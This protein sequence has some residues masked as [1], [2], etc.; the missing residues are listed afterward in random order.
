MRLVGPPCD[1]DFVV[2]CLIVDDSV[3]FLSS[4]RRLLERQGMAVAGVASSGAEALLRV[5]E[6]QPD[7]V[8]LDI[9]LGGENGL[10]VAERLDGAGSPGIIMISTHA[11]QDYRDLIAASPAVGF[12]SKGSLSAHAIQELLDR[13]L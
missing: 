12:L 8:L 7:V 13:G 6:L 1:A 2:L 3:G 11:E 5:E 9:E 4:A 10:D